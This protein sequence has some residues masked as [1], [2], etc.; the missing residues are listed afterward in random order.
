MSDS[1]PLLERY[2]P[3]PPDGQHR[4]NPGAG[5]H[6]GDKRWQYGKS[7]I[8]ELSTKY[9]AILSLEIQGIS[10]NDIARRMGM[11]L[12]GVIR[13]TSSQKYLDFRNNY[14][15]GLDDEFFAM[16]PL[17]FAA[18]KQGLSS[19]D[20]DTALKASDQWFKAAAFGGYSKTSEPHSNLTAE[21]VVRQL[22]HVQADNVQININ[23]GE[24]KE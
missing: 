10:K 20:E 24:K 19:Q 2:F 13:A 6:F 16:K 14:L 8:D 22:L 21:D 9:R 5:E 7:E 15:A 11:S 4:H 12:Q 18:L 1:N 23:T 17:A 3:P